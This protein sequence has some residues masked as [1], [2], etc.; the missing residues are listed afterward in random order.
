MCVYLCTRA[1]AIVYTIPMDELH[2]YIWKVDL[3]NISF[4]NIV[5]CTHINYIINYI[6]LSM[7]THSYVQ[8]WSN[9]DERRSRSSRDWSEQIHIPYD[10]RNQNRS[11]LNQQNNKTICDLIIHTCPVTINQSITPRSTDPPL[12]YSAISILSWSQYI[13]LHTSIQ[14]Q[15]HSSVSAFLTHSITFIPLLQESNHPS[16]PIQ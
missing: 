1:W 8:C 11:I 14:F 7:N 9:L 15:S 3:C 16:V 10:L 5:Q 2:S 12:S 6:I 4:Y 13:L